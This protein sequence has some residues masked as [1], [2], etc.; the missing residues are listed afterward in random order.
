M[1]MDRSPLITDA[2]QGHSPAA[3]IERLTAQRDKLLMAIKQ[4]IALMSQKPDRYG[5]FTQGGIDVL[6]EAIAAVEG[7]DDN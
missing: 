7:N 5:Q 1:P 2:P 4:A 3:R 6:K